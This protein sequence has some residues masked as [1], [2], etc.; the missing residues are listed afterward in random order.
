MARGY[1]RATNVTYLAD[2]ATI[3]ARTEFRGKGDPGY[4]LTSGA[5]LSNMRYG[6]WS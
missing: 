1:I 6:G 4:L 3:R 2:D 5:C